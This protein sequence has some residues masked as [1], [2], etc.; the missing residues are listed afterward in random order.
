M[1]K[2]TSFLLIAIMA[3]MTQAHLMRNENARK[4][5]Q[6]KTQVHATRMKQTL[7]E[8]VYILCYTSELHVHIFTGITY[9][10]T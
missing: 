5:I 6:G 8:Y 2:L 3:E 9:K 1:T 7:H 10:H 4:E